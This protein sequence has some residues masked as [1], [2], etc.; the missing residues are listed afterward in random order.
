LR[1]L[2]YAALDLDLFTFLYLGLFH[3]C[4]HFLIANTTTTRPSASMMTD[5]TP[6][7]GLY[8]KNP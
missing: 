1:A 6:I 3:N 2:F 8:I 7:I 5:N 4:A